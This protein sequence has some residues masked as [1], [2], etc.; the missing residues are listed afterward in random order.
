[1][2]EE[3]HLY[4]EE[5]EGRFYYQEGKSKLPCVLVAHAWK[6]QDDFARDKAQELA[7]CG[8]VGFAI[9]LYGGAKR[10][11][12][13]EEAF[14]M[15]SPLYFDRALLQKRLKAA[16]DEACN[17]P[18][19]DPQKIAVIGF[20]FGGLAAIE[21]FKSGLDVKGAVSFHGLL[22]DEMNGKKAKTLPMQ[23]GIKG[24][25]L[26]LHGYDDPLV[27]ASDVARCQNELNEAGVD[28]QMHTYGQT[29]HAFTV[30][31][32]DDPSMGLKYNATSEKR[33]F[34][35]MKS[36]FEEVF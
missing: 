27:S 24:S 34:R 23:S 29:K 14:E 30:V 17:H 3:K 19:V 20:C 11:E 21:L 10:V 22:S 33:A 9:D 15:M 26:I 32:A 35:S 2:K 12:T 25:L 36:F 8:Y 18:M 5:F 31:G 16:F 6:G 7:K 4:G 28:W 1:M 13:K